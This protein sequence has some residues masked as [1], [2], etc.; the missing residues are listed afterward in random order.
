MK[1][2]L[3]YLHRGF[4]TNHAR[5]GTVMRRLIT[6]I[7]AILAL[8]LPQD[9]E[10][11]QRLALIITNQGYP[12]QLGALSKSHADGEILSQKL[13]QVGFEVRQVK[14]ADKSAMLGAYRN[15]RSDS[16]RQVQ[17]A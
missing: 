13:R 5:T 16:K 7:I 1:R 4:A 12:P 11:E 17:A 9:A 10:A 3:C 2:Y 6:L 8:I 14:D 15:T